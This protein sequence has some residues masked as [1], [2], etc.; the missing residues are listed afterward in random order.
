MQNNIEKFTQW[1]VLKNGFT[2]FHVDHFKIL[3][4]IRVLAILELFLFSEKLDTADNINGFLD[5]LLSSFEAGN[6]QQLVQP[7]D[8]DGVANNRFN[9][10]FFRV[11][12]HVENVYL[13]HKW[14]L[15][16]VLCS[17][18][19]LCRGDGIAD[20]TTWYAWEITLRIHLI[21]F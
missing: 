2:S 8:W 11:L 3:N 9:L 18:F 19:L 5:F 7:H 1:I 14:L 15:F 20:E 16:K 13:A 4:D 17:F 12:Q 10:E 21:L 6:V